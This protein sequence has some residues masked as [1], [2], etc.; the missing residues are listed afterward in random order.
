VVLSPHFDDDVIGCGGTLRLFKKQG[1]RVTVIYM[2]DGRK[3]DPGMDRLSLSE[4]ERKIREDGLA[5]LRKE[6]AKR[7]AEHMSIDRLVF[8]DLPD[9]EFTCTPSVVDRV[10]GLLED[11][12]PDAVF[13]PF[14]TEKHRDHRM[15]NTIFC[16]ALE[17]KNFHFT[18]YGY[19][20]WTALPPNCLVDI[21]GVLEDKKTAIAQ[22]QSQLEHC[23][24]IRAV[25]CL[26]G[27]RA[28]VF[29]EGPHYAE[30]F[31]RASTALYQFLFRQMR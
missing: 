28:M 17:K 2:T 8:L 12:S 13:V 10:A 22:H 5:D 14:L 26:N 1:S 31:Y 16:R 4:E 6:E 9:M 27:Y 20:V 11:E 3:G 23:D 19:E 30:A 24:F 21:T 15:T 25:T 18:C 7:T 29:F